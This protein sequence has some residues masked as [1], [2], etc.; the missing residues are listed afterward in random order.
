MRFR[1]PYSLPGLLT[2]LSAEPTHGRWGLPQPLAQLR[3]VIRLAREGL[4]EYGH[5]LDALERQVAQP[6]W[7]RDDDPCDLPSVRRQ[8][9]D[10]DVSVTCRSPAEA[11]CEVEEPRLTQR[12]VHHLFEKLAI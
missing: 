4:R 3:Q 12:E 6:A 1:Q 11:S 7:D 2:L 9:T 10:E 8:R 5:R